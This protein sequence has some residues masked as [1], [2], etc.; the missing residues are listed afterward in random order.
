MLPVAMLTVRKSGPPEMGTCLGLWFV[1]TL[2]VAAF[3][4][5]VASSAVGS[6]GNTK[7]GAHIVGML[8]FIAYGGGSIQMGIWMGKPWGSVA[9]D[10]LDSVIYAVISALVFMWLWPAG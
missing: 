4:A 1:F 10:M 3:A 9:K 5:C 2:G 6:G 8:S 7:M